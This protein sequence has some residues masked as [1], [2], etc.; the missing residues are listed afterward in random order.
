MTRA[1]LKPYAGSP[2]PAR[3]QRIAEGGPVGPRGVAFLRRVR[4]AC[5]AYR[6]NRNV[7]RDALDRTLSGGFVRRD[8]FDRDSVQLT[9]AGADYLDRLMRVD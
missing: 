8:A 5:G 4:A 6:I 3:V 1:Q 9:E 2:Q 7:D